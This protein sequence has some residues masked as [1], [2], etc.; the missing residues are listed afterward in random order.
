ME[1]AG[2]NVEVPSPVGP[3]QERIEKC[4]EKAHYNQKIKF[5]NTPAVLF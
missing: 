5:L 1:A 2:E 4:A 3:S